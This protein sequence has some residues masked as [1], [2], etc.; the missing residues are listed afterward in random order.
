M[1]FTTTKQ[2][3]SYIEYF[4]ELYFL[5]IYNSTNNKNK[6]ITLYNYFVKK[7]NETNKFNL[8]VESL[9]MEVKSKILHG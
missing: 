8:D 1:I 4:I 6:L 5:K 3:T 9:L 2:L 7:T